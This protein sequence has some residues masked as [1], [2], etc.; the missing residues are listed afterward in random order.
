MT[1]LTIRIV[2]VTLFLPL[3]MP[4]AQRPSNAPATASAGKAPDTVHLEELTW[5]EVR[6]MIKAG[7][8]TVIVGT[9]GTEQK[10]PHMVDGEH[11]FVMEY[12]GD[13][14]ARAIGKTLVA[15]VVTYVPE[16][17]WEN[18]SGHM[19]KPGTITLPGRSLRRT[20]RQ[21]RTQPEGRRIQ[22]DPLH[23]RVGRQSQ[24]HADR[25]R[26]AQRAVE[27]RRARARSGS[28]T[29]TRKSHADQN[30]YI[31]EK[32]GIPADKIGGH[33]NILDTSE[34]LFVNPK[35]VRKTQAAPATTTR[36]TASAANPS[37]STPELG[38]VF[39][40]IKIDNALAQI[41]ALM[42]GTRPRQQAE[43]PRDAPARAGA[44][45]AAAAA[46]AAA[47]RRRRRAPRTIAAD[48]DDGARRAR[49]RRR[50][51]TRSS[52]TR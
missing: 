4:T 6:D 37:K 21:C 7:T 48:D 2:L 27:R 46:A 22:D 23:R 17:S 51:P 33:A 39:L 49:R 30:K 16:G 28:T 14:I 43:P 50:R 42:A 26:E 45:G 36:T 47:G 29:T 13:K 11:K 34:L 15:P 38:K 41:K 20:A 40:Q 5:A 9:A 10:G 25:G 31:T 1:K 19:A 18:P 24:R 44:A 32:L 52:S 12:A 35:H 8:T 3:A